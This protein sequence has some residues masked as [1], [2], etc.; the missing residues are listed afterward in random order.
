MVLTPFRA[1]TYVVVARGDDPQGRVAPGLNGYDFVVFGGGDYSVVSVA[2]GVVVSA[3]VE[4][5]SGATIK[6][7]NNEGQFDI[8]SNLRE[9]SFLV[10]PGDPVFAGQAIGIVGTTSLASYTQLRFERRTIENDASSNIQVSFAD[11][12]AEG[13][14]RRGEAW[15]SSTVSAGLAAGPLSALPVNTPPAGDARTAL[16]IF[17]AAYYLASYSDLRSFYGPTNFDGA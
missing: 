10:R 9:N 1:G 15:T 11:K 4:D 16:P 2:P 8:Y 12:G 14:T 17:D 7:R 5:G 13:L 6:I 3:R